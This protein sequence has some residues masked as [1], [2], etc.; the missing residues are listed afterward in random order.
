MTKGKEER[1]K[2]YKGKEDRANDDKGQEP[3]SIR[4]KEVTAN[5]DIKQG[6]KQTMTKGK[7]DNAGTRGQK[8]IVSND[9]RQGRKS[10]HR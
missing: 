3:T 10:R 1:A 2:V 8:E 6:I 7:G 4:G 9:K 5:D